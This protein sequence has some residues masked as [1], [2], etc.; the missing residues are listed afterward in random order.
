MLKGKKEIKSSNKAY[1]NE[2]CITGVKIENLQDLIS[3][4]KDTLTVAYFQIVIHVGTNNIFIANE[5]EIIDA[6]ENTC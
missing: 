1:I 5:T 6:V 3:K 2:H 4:I